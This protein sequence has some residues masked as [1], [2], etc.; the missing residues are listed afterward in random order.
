MNCSLRLL[1]TTCLTAAMLY[2]VPNSAYANPQGGVVTA[3]QA[4]ISEAG[5]KLDIIQQSNKAVIDWRGFDIAPDEHTQFHQPSS[6]SI[7]LNRVNSNSASQINGQLTAN[8]NVVIVNQNGILFGQNAKVD[9][10]GL[11]ATTADI[12]NDKFMQN[13]LL[14]SFDCSY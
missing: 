14:M 12:D 11:V 4:S 7:T 10:N 1:S 5:K 8:G 3:G 2:A 13:N 9:V 6:S